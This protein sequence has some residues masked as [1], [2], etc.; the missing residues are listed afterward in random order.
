MYERRQFGGRRLTFRLRVLMMRHQ[1]SL[2]PDARFE[3]F[4]LGRKA[5]LMLLHGST[6]TP[7]KREK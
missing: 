4:S 3:A 5:I 7:H 6:V 2:L 1:S